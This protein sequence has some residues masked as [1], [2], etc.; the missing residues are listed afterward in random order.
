M[1]HVQSEVDRGAIERT[2]H[3]AYKQLVNLHICDAEIGVGGLK[4]VA[5]TK[6]EVYAFKTRLLESR[7]EAMARK[8][9]SVLALVMDFAIGTDSAAVNNARGI[10][11]KRTTRR[12][13]RPIIPSPAQVKALLDN[14]DKDFRCLLMTA[15]F[16][17]L[18]PSELY[19][20]NWD[21]VVFGKEPCI[22]VRQRA[23]RYG[24]I[25]DPKS[26]A[27]DRDVPIGPVLARK[28][29]ALKLKSTHAL[30]FPNK[31]GKP[32]QQNNVLNRQYKPLIKKAKLVD[33][34]G[35]RL[36]RFYDLRHFAI[37]HWIVQGFNAKEIQTW[38]GH[39]SIKVTYDVY[40]HLFPDLEDTSA[41]LSAIE[42]AVLD[43]A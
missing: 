19:G 7:S 23:D 24:E 4:T 20:L 36:F 18:R 14:A 27:A 15:A 31:R 40:G 11:I 10:K 34:K 2:T 16:T 33:G 29:K 3:N 12:K 21:N 9:I 41:A 6:G 37:S 28:L 17:G 39:S 30:V 26:V 35:R 5:L 32:K 22:C 43:S 38:A 25:G 8:S 1:A 42:S 13:S